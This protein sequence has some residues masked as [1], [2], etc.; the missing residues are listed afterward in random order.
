MFQMRP[1]PKKVLLVANTSWYLYNFRRPLAR[2]LRERGL[3]PILL[4]PYDDYSQ[5]LVAEGFAWRELSLPRARLNPWRELKSLLDLLRHYRREQPAAVH[6]FTIKCV[7]YGTIAALAARVPVRINAVTGLGHVFLSRSFRTALLRGPLR[8]AYRWTLGVAAS[9]VIFQNPDD[10]KSFVDNGLVAASRTFLIRSSGVDIAA[11]SPARAAQLR[12]SRSDAHFRVLFAGRLLREKGVFELV[13]AI[14]LLKSRPETRGI[15]FAVAGEL[16]AA[17][18]SS[19]T[20]AELAQWRNEGI[21][22]FLGHVDPIADAL[23]SSDLVVL[24]SYREGTPKILLEACSMEKPVIATDAPGCREVVEHERNGL[25]VPVQDAA[26]LAEA[27][28]RLAADPALCAR[29]GKAGRLKVVN[30]FSD[31]EI[32]RQTLQVYE[33]LGVLEVAA[34]DRASEEPRAVALG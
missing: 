18:P 19:V 7:I 16:Y 21:A 5:R 22:Q 27:I 31:V 11:F 25:L 29:L 32:A 17:N 4:S 34:V 12:V 8:L 20:P 1:A 24:P 14:R 30:E 9:R 2:A 13:E 10:L 15:E 3:E 6:H 28:A 33:T 23:A 26:A